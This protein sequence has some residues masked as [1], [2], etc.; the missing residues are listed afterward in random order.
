M[1]YKGCFKFC[2]MNNIILM[3]YYNE[4]VGCDNLICVPIKY[5]SYILNHIII[6]AGFSFY[7]IEPPSKTFIYTFNIQ[8]ISAN[9]Q[10]ININTYPVQI[11]L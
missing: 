10:S 6:P 1:L 5:N 4:S 11:S 9:F 7:L 3:H 2:N 8:I